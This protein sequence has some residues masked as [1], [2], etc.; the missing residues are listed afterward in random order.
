MTCFHSQWF[1][2]ERIAESIGSSSLLPG[3]PI[4]GNLAA[5]LQTSLVA[6]VNTSSYEDSVCRSSV[7]LGWMRRP[8]SRC[9]DD[10]QV[11]V[12]V[13]GYQEP[14]Q[15]NTLMVT[16]QPRL[17]TG[18]ATVSVD[19]RGILLEEPSD[20]KP[21]ENLDVQNP[22]QLERKLNV[23]SQSNLFI[24]RSQRSGWHNDSFASE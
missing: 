22:E 10:L 9:T 20:V 18:E 7:A 23:V 16:C 13:S 17:I 24:F 1:G 19:K 6:A 5:E 12:H 3:E 21:H 15:H 8:G 14:D 11:N 2:G 4:P